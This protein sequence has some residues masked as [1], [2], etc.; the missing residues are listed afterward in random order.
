MTNLLTTSQQKQIIKDILAKKNNQEEFLELM[1]KRREK[2]IIIAKKC[3]NFLNQN[4]EVTKIMLFGSL[5]DYKKMTFNSDIDLAVWNLSE[6]DYFKAVGF[7]LE[8]AED[9]TIDLVEIENAKPYILES[10]NEGIEL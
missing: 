10:I 7:L 9:F 2:G 4:Y 8:I 5:L 3:A 1:E 6:K